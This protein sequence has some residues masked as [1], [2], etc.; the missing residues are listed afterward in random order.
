MALPENPDRDFLKSL[1]AESRIQFLQSKLGIDTEELAEIAEGALLL[2]SLGG[3]LVGQ[4][5]KTLGP[6]ALARDAPG[7]IFVLADQVGVLFRWGDRGSIHGTNVCPAPDARLSMALNIDMIEAMPCFFCARDAKLT[8][9][10]VIP[11][12]LRG[13]LRDTVRWEIGAWYRTEFELER[14]PAIQRRQTDQI[15]RRVCGPCNSGWMS[16]LEVEVRPLLEPLIAGEVLVVSA[17]DQELL[18]RWALKTAAVLGPLQ[19]APDAVSPELRLRLAESA[20]LDNRVALWAVPLPAEETHLYQWHFGLS[21]EEPYETPACSITGLPL[22]RIGFEVVNLN[23][24]EELAPERL[25]ALIPNYYQPVA[26]P[27]AGPALLPSPTAVISPKQAGGVP[28]GMRVPQM[29]G[30]CRE[31]GMR[32][33]ASPPSD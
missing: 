13:P 31:M 33:K 14:T 3:C 7:Q 30:I 27:A 5:P 21:V 2:F 11:R 8:R 10:H 25:P 19:R 22:G 1:T 32:V 6:L 4:H 20:P 29:A 12:W 9:E 15:L 24:P 18:R 26:P 16:D 23:D 17:S 28:F